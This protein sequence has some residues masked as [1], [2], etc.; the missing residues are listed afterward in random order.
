[1]LKYS[2]PITPGSRSYIYTDRSGL[3]KDRPHRALT[4]YH[5]R[6]K[7]R[8]NAGRITSRHLGG[9]HKRLYRIIDFKRDVR[10]IEGVITKIEY[11]PNRT[12]YIA[13]VEYSNKEVRYILA[14]HSLNV[15]DK[16]IA[17][18]KKVDPNV[19]CAMPL[20]EIP[21][22]LNIHNIELKIGKGGQVARSAGVY[23]TLMAKDSTNATIKLKSG[24]MR[25]VNLECFATIGTLSNPD[26]K[27]TQVG[28]AG[29]SRWKGKRPSVRGVAM[30]PVDHPH[31]GGEGKTGGG[32]HPV[33]PWGKLTKGKKTRHNKRT[34]KMIL[35]HRGK[36]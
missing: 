12:C 25:F 32:R 28:K 16:I 19:G 34:Q 4:E 11:D 1:M 5:H 27:N 15:G 21:V 22:G 23:A 3:S 26:H 31:G 7:G 35:R 17:S 24:E 20:R 29:R 36:K 30:N 9:G 14:P 13:L 33:S 18:S 10:D 8:N 6:A 2:K